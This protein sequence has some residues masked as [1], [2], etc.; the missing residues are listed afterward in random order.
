MC[1]IFPRYRYDLEEFPAM[2]FGV[3]ARAQSYDTWSKRVTES[4]AADQKSKKGF[5]TN[6][7]HLLNYITFVAT[8]ARV[9][10]VV[11]TGTGWPLMATWVVP[12]PV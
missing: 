3:K 5:V 8:V 1:K 11:P 4:L 10:I 2:L 9:I 7:L 12:K 6:Y